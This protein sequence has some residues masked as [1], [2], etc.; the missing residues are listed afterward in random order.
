MSARGV[1]SVS[2]RFPRCRR[3]AACACLWAARFEWIIGPSQ[4]HWTSVQRMPPSNGSRLRLASWQL[5]QSVSQS[6]D[7]QPEPSG[8]QLFGG[9]NRSNFG[10]GLR[11]RIQR[12]PPLYSEAGPLLGTAANLAHRLTEYRGTPPKPP[13]QLIATPSRW[14]RDC[15]VYALGDHRLNWCRR[16][17]RITGVH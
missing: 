3:P 11:E 14:T 15:R 7:G 1:F 2:S 6:V 10:V 9:E 12:G 4:A 13:R 17:G 5:I 16:I 8:G